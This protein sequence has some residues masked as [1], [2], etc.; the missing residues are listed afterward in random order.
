MVGLSTEEDGQNNKSVSSK[1]GKTINLYP[2][3]G[4]VSTEEDGQNN[5]SVSSNGR[6]DRG[7]LSTEEDGQNNK[8]VSSKW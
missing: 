4:R 1:Y 8:S 3:N 7:R 5:K 6:V 2:L